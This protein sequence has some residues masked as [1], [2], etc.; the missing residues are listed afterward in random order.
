LSLFACSCGGGE[1]EYGV[2]GGEVAESGELPSRDD[3]RRVLFVRGQLARVLSCLALPVGAA[4]TADGAQG[5]GVPA[6][7]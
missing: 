7:F 4:L 5:G 1:S 3:E 2:S 6:A